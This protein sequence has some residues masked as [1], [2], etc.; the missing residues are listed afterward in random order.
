MRIMPNG[1][2]TYALRYALTSPFLSFRVTLLPACQMIFCRFP[3]DS[4]QCD[5][6]ISSIAYPKTNVNFS[7]NASPVQ[8]SSKISLPE[9][10]VKSLTPEE[11]KVEGKLSNP[12]LLRLFKRLN[13]VSSSCLM[14]VFSLER[15]GARYIVERYIPSTLAMMFAWVAPFVPYNYEDVRIITPITV[16]RLFFICVRSSRS[17]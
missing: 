17:Y 3:H 8:F 6:R 1:L 11:C 12:I 15:D 16:R 7:W 9:L 4:Q 2:V 10:R 5:L 14:L 13:S